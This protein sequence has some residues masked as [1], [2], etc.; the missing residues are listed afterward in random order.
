M[1]LAL[2]LPQ[3]GQEMLACAVLGGVLGG[4]RACFPKKGKAAFL[5]DLLY[6]GVL[7]LAL[8]SYAAGSSVGGVMRWYMVGSAAASAAAV[9]TLLGLPG[10]ILRRHRKKSLKKIQKELAK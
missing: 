2:A 3:I 5:P 7:L 6:V 10:R 4:V 8:Q 9:G 1:A